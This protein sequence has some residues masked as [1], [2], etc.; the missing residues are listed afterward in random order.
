MKS[1]GISLLETIVSV[2]ILLIVSLFCMAI[3]GQGQ[4]HD[5]RA[6][7]FST[8]T[9]LANQKM[10]EFLSKPTSDLRKELASP[11]AAKFSGEFADYS[12][13]AVLSNYEPGLSSLEVV[14]KSDLGCF[15]RCQMMVPEEVFSR[16]IGADQDT[17]RIYFVGGPSSGPSNTTLSSFWDSGGA[18]SLQNTPANPDG[19][20]ISGLAGSPG[21]GFLWGI[22]PDGN[23]VGLNENPAPGV[24]QAAETNPASDLPI[25]WNSIACDESTHVVVA[26]D[27]GNRCLRIYDYDWFPAP[28]WHPD[29]CKPESNSLGVPG[30]VVIDPYATLVW[31]A[32][33]END[34]LRKFLRSATPPPGYPASFLEPWPNASAPVGFW[35]T[36]SFRPSG[37][38]L[39]TPAGLAMSDGGSRVFVA[40]AGG[41]WVF[42]EADT[43][44]PWK[45]LCDYSGSGGTPPKPAGLACDRF[46]TVVYVNCYDGRILKAIENGPASWSIQRI[47]P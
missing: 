7:Q 31:V 25:Q 23:L 33:R 35:D 39:G 28:Y 43:A 3:F 41:L 22:V 10:Q 15:S 36:R 44:I 13:T 16:G 18:V 4:R 38:F 37:D 14:A 29:A 19:K 42:E 47:Y 40:D 32:D 17:S 6:R 30:A 8:C 24:W 9:F 34:C 5:L 1:R 21:Q 11:M 2:Q 45:R 12:Y 27:V 46:G 26:S 20:P